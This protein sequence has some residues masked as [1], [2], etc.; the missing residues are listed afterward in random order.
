MVVNVDKGVDD[1]E[2]KGEVSKGATQT[3]G[4]LVE[5]KMQVSIKGELSRAW[6]VVSVC[7]SLSY[8]SPSTCWVPDHVLYGYTLILEFCC[9]KRSVGWSDLRRNDDN[10]NNNENNSA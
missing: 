4:S 1:E 5:T 6:F 9:T 3:P 8:S 7:L 2:E 10:H